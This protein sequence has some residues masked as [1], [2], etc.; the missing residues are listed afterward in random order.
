[1]I[2][3]L[4]LIPIV[5][6]FGTIFYA[7]NYGVVWQE[8]ILL[9]IGWWLSG[10]GITFGYHRLFAHRSFKAH[11][12]VQF[13]AMLFG[14]AALQN[15]II[16]WSSD[17]RRHHKNLDTEKDPYSITKGFFHAHIGWILL[18]EPPIVKG[19]ND[20]HENSV[21]VFQ[22]KYYWIISIFMA[23]LLPLLIGS[24]Y[25]RPFGGLLWGGF[26]RVTLV[27]HFTFFINSLC[28]FIGKR[29][30]EIRTTA[31][32]SWLMAYFTFGE[33]FHNFHHKFQWDYRNGIRWFDYDPGK[34]FIKLLSYFKLT[35]D[36]KKV[37]DYQIF[38]AKLDGLKQRL[39]EFYPKLPDR[40]MNNYSKKVQVLQQNARNIYESWKV[41]EKELIRMKQNNIKNKVEF[42]LLKQKQKL[43]RTQYYKILNGLTLML[44]DLQNNNY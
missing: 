13:V 28:H 12:V 43:Y 44:Y 16:K 5:G 35:K 25:G 27:H 32:D 24:L 14:S 42:L 10:M 18:D 21:V 20:L 30:Y 1:M 6:F 19:V 33:G 17:H 3:A 9:F 7:F 34:W 15:T 29:P 39:Q 22:S 38:Q 31:R 41:V 26:L 2:S 36:I 23:F 8:P 11:P 4:T 37:K 40:I